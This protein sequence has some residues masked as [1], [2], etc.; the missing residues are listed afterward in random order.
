MY[1]DKDLNE[2]EFYWGYYRGTEETQMDPW[3]I[4]LLSEPL[5]LG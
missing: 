5:L 1:Y 4:E 3:V 2:K